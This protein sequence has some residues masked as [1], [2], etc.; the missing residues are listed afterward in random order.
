MHHP[1]TRKLVTTALTIALVTLVTIAVQIPNSVGGYF[2]LGDSMIFAVALIGGPAAAALAG[3]VGSALADILSG[4]A[5][6]ALPSLLVKGTEGLVAGLLFRRML[7]FGHLRL[8]SL[9]I[10]LVTAFAGLLMVSGYFLTSSI[11]Y[12]YPA[13]VAAVPADLIQAFISIPIGLSL[14]ALLRRAGI[15]RIFE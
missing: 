5:S 6:W 4:Y 7:R 11:L 9:R 13:A 10:F 15:N 2:N 3:G 14:A 1:N 12:G 8:L